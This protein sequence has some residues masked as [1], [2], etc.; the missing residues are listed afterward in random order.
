MYFLY[1]DESGDVGRQAGSTNFFAL[2]GMVFHE[3]VWHQT[4]DAIIQFRKHLRQAYGFKLR[5]EIH[6]KAMIHKPGSLARI[7]KSIRLRILRDVLDFIETLP[8]VSLLHILVDKTRKPVGYDVFD[9]AW[10][11]LFQVGKGMLWGMETKCC[12]C[13]HQTH[14]RL[15]QQTADRWHTI[16]LAGAARHSGYQ[17]SLHPG[18]AAAAERSGWDRTNWW[19][20]QMD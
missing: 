19:P 16:D 13:L 9:N 1:V 10:R 11:A 7:N 18:Q 3:L 6:C 14:Q 15:S 17:L 20:Q 8:D 12:R 5:E 4:L 2:S